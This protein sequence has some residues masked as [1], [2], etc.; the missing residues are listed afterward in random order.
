MGSDKI[1]I[2]LLG[3][4]FDHLGRSFVFSKKSLKVKHKFLRICQSSLLWKMSISVGETSIRL[5]LERYDVFGDESTTSMLI[6]FNHFGLNT[7]WLLDKHGNSTNIQPFV[8]YWFSDISLSVKKKVYNISSES[9]N[10]LSLS[11]KT[12]L[13]IVKINR[14]LNEKKK[15]K[16]TSCTN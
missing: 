10:F 14:L 11:K 15:H 9:M 1:Y 6:V 5:R 2:Y 3:E 7:F 4:L 12:L 8:S 13:P 16:N